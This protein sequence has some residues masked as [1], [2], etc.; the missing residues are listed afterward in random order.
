MPL[1]DTS[2]TASTTDVLPPSTAG[3]NAVPPRAGTRGAAGRRLRGWMLRAGRSRSGRIVIGLVAVLVY[4]SSG[5][6]LPSYAAA[7]A[8]A[9][10]EVV[11]APVVGDRL[12]GALVPL[13]AV[14]PIRESAAE[15][16]QAVLFIHGWLSTSLPGA[17]TDQPGIAQSPFAH[18]SAAEAA[19]DEITDS[20]QQSL[21]SLP[22]TTLYAFDYSQTAAAWIGGSA[23]VDG[24]AASIRELALETR[25]PVDVVAHSMG[26]LALRHAVAAHPD[27]VPLI[28]QVITVG[29]PTLGSDAAT[30]LD[31]VSLATGTVI[32][33]GSAGRALIVPALVDLCNRDL[34]ADAMN[35]C[36]LPTWLRTSIANTGEAGRALH[37]GSRE[38]KDMPDWPAALNVHAIAGD[39][40]LRAG[41]LV[42]SLGDGL[43]SRE[44]AVAEA[45]TAFVVRCEDR[46]APGL[47]GVGDV[48]GGKASVSFGGVGCT[49]DQLLRNPEVVENVRA[50][51]AGQALPPANPRLP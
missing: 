51:I 15:P 14:D 6:P 4:S 28:G 38:L 21:E 22:G 39:G 48:L 32:G 45:D 42:V 25:A 30:L 18:Q 36:G 13:S 11:V 47:T 33:A 3:D 20:L 41:G 43:V 10:A 7:P 2:H 29:T 16:A 5:V 34:E 26:G 19:V 40:R 27:L 9:P 44:S 31:V 17:A 24:L 8:P 50:V 35:G 46:V 37:A 23:V 1:S 49:H 12:G